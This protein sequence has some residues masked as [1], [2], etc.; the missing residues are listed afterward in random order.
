MDSDVPAIEELQGIC[1]EWGATL[2]VDMAHDF[3]ALGPRG[4]RA[5]GR[6]DMLGKVDLVMGAFSKTFASNGGFLATRSPAVRQYVRVFGGPH[7]FSNALSPVQATV[8]P[9]G[10]G[11]RPLGGGRRAARAADVQRAHP[12]RARSP[13]GGSTAWACPPPVVPVPIGDTADG[14]HRRAHAGRQYAVFANLVEFPAVPIKGSR[15]RMQVMATHT[16]EQ[17]REAAATVADT[18]EEARAFVHGDE[19]SRTAVAAD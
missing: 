5:W 1:R 16:A 9:R 18:I 17:V 4:R 13:S 6:S 15:F 12:S 2:L 3:G 14:A 7:I 10:A 11:D 8:V 19:E